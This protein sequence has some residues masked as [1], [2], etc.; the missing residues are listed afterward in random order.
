MYY[1]T[2]MQAQAAFEAEKNRKAFIYTVIICA[3]ILLLA[4]LIKFRID[5]VIPPVVQDLIEV[6]LGNNDEGYG[7]E[8]PLIKGEMSPSVPVPAPAQHTAATTAKDEPSKDI[9][10]DDNADEEAAP[11]KKPEKVV[12][13]TTAVKENTAKPSKTTNTNNPVTTPPAP[14]PQKPKYSYNGPGNGNG[15]GA[16]QDNGYTMQGNKPGGKG[17]AGDPAGKPDSY[18]NNPGGK[19]AGGALRVSKGDRR[20][21][22]NYIFMGDLPK[23]T[24]NAIIKV[25][26]DGRGTFVS[27]DKGSTSTDSRYASAIRSYLP[28][29]QFDKSDHESIVTVPFNFR[30]N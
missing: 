18:G 3:I 6:N 17:D 13:K 20:I 5:K 29:I 21:V 10:P 30:V 26:P 19:V 28:N 12:P 16:T 23:A 7:E 2:T 1:S 15:N 9:E 4:F 25:S 27:I 11:V 22:N 14:K 24:I 8:Q